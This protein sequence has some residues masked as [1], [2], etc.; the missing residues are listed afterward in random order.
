[1]SLLFFVFY[2]VLFTACASMRIPSQNPW[3][4]GDSLLKC[5]SLR[6]L[7]RRQPSTFPLLLSL[8]PGAGTLPVAADKCKEYQSSDLEKERKRCFIL[9]KDAVNLVAT[10][11]LDLFFPLILDL[12]PSLLTPS[13]Y[14]EYAGRC[15]FDELLITLIYFINLT[16]VEPTALPKASEI[17]VH[18]FKT[19]AK[20]LTL[21]CHLP[22]LNLVRLCRMISNSQRLKMCL[23]TT[24]KSQTQMRMRMQMKITST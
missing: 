3:F 11:L 20:D 6:N 5:S 10:G 7:R 8:R 15:P 9:A 14:T 23:A 22:R 2:L 4:N 12:S 24:T 18:L 17:I 1:M 19:W 21:H 16:D 13:S